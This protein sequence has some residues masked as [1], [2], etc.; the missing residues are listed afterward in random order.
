MRN[1]DALA[2]V[3]NRT[4][5]VHGS[6]FFVYLSQVLNLGQLNPRSTRKGPSVR[7][8]CLRSRVPPTQTPH[9]TGWGESG[10]IPFQ[11]SRLGGGLNEWMG[12][13]RQ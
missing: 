12:N 9:T 2:D 1:F 3:I 7:S 11:S 8:S 10:K 5:N 4:A 13:K 6:L